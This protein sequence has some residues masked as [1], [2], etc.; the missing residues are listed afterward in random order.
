MHVTPINS[1]EGLFVWAQILWLILLVLIPMMIITVFIIWNRFDRNNP[2]AD[3]A[4]LCY[5]FMMSSGL[6]SMIIG[7][8][9]GVSYRQKIKTISLI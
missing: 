9:L 2:L 3:L 5:V 8:I 4:G 7:I 6:I 1:N